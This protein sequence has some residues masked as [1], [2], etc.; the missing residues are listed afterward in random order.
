MVNFFKRL[1]SKSANGLGLEIAPERLNIVQLRKQ[2]PGYTLESFATVEIPEGLVE[3]GLI[4]DPPEMALLIQETLAEHNLKPKRVATS[5][6]AREGVIR[7]I[8]VPKELNELEL[9][10]YMNQEAGLYLPFPREEADVDYQKLGEFMDEDGIEKVQVLL[11][12]TR[13]D[14]T[15]TYISTFQEAGLKMD[16]LE[17]SSFALLRTIREQLLQLPPEEAVVVTDLQFDSTEIAIVVDGIPQFS[18]TIP[19]GTYQVQSA[20]S[21]AMNLPPSR[22]TDMLQGMTIPSN[23]TESTGSGTMGAGANPGTQ[24]MI[25]VFSELADE[26][27]R[28]IDF[29]VNQSEGLEVSQ[30]MLAGPG[31]AIGGLDDF[32]NQR[33]SLLTTVVDPV[34]N[35][36]LEVDEEQIPL[37]Q[38]PGLGVVLGLAMREA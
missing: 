38:R 29:Y 4:A 2:G 8:P 30:M 23:P 27:R 32:F 22:N 26:L 33:L 16:I 24:A 7:I 28:S 11:V 10:E 15:D 3:E 37:V 31:A 5:V 6:P 20:L 9:R 12:A 19:I 21:Q 1:F 13:K 35:L 25:K 34:E 14:V 17:V 36:S 18:R